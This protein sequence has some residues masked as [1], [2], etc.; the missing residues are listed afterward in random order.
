MIIDWG[1]SHQPSL[2][3]VV[4]WST[5]FFTAAG[6]TVVA[7]GSATLRLQVQAAPVLAG[8]RISPAAAQL[9]LRVSAAGLAVGVS[10]EV[11]PLTFRLIVQQ[12][13]RIGV[14][15]VN[16]TG[17]LPFVGVGYRGVYKPYFCWRR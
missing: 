10:V 9:R 15:P 13:S 16:D 17:R 7:P 6:D 1:L 14:I 5:G 4:E 8:V 2:T 12:P 3:G 11:L